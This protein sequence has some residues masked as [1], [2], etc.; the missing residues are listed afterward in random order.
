MA[1][2]TAILYKYRRRF[3]W[4]FAASVLVLVI[5]IASL[6]TLSAPVPMSTSP[7]PVAQ[8]GGNGGGGG[9]GGGSGS[10][11]G[12]GG[13][14]GNAQPDVTFFISL[15]SLAT[16]GASLAGFLLTS[17]LAWRKERRESKHSEV[18][19]ERKRLEVEK[20]K[21]ELAAKAHDDAKTNSSGTE[22]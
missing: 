13:G 11:Q 6:F 17:G 21:M 22:A 3:L 20:L 18:D 8:P 7:P 2:S 15:A 4:A 10:G 19:L 16:S 5:S 12:S 9:G 1:L 14:S